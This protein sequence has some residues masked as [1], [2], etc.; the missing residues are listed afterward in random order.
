MIHE[1]ELEIEEIEE[2]DEEQSVELESEK[3]DDKGD[4]KPDDTKPEETATQTKRRLD[5]RAP[6]EK[7]KAAS[8]TYFLGKLMI[9]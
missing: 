9:Y 6:I 3:L 1:D 8:L 4:A 2:S 5:A 7:V